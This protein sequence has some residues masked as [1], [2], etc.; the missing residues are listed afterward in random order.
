MVQENIASLFQ[1]RPQRDPVQGEAEGEL[2]L[3]PVC[4]KKQCLNLPEQARSFPM[5]QAVRLP[6]QPKD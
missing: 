3:F 5:H 4:L 6:S 1:P 2:A